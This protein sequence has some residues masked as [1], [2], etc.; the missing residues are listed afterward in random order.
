VLACAVGWAGLGLAADD[1]PTPVKLPD[2]EI[3]KLLLGRWENATR[4]NGMTF[5]TLETFHKDGTFERVDTNNGQRTAY[6]GKWELQKGMLAIEPTDG[7]FKGI[8]VRGTIT[9]IDEKAQKITMEAGADVT[10]T[11]PKD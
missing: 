1:K 7:P 3:A 5:H 11:R 4:I 10:K 9:A 6:K 2:E 8:K